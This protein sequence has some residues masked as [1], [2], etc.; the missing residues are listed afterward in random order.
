M[1]I[2]F[3]HKL[4]FDM[5]VSYLVKNSNKALGIIKLIKEHLHLNCII[6]LHKTSVWP[7]LEYNS[8][9][10]NDLSLTKSNGKLFS[11]RRWS[12]SSS[13]GAVGL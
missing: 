7:T 9:V 2:F 1:G 4:T 5:H 13:W 10:W 6:I 11:F 3:D 8:V 12:G